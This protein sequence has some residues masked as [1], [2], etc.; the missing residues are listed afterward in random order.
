MYWSDWGA[1]PHIG[2]AGMDG[3]AREVLISAGLGWPNALTV[4]PASEELYFADAREDYIAVADLDGKR[5]RVLF[6]RGE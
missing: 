6:S 5:V 4:V 2:R 1:H 3:S